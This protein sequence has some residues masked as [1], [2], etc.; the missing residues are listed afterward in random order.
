MSSLLTYQ[1]REGA[2]EKGEDYDE[3]DGDR[4]HPRHGVFS[5]LHVWRV[6][7]RQ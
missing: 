7:M 5:D 1:Y 6:T 2:E 3:E 4:A